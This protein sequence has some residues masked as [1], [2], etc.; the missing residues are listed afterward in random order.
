MLHM[1]QCTSSTPQVKSI[2]LNPILVFPEYPQCSDLVV[3]P[4]KDVIDSLLVHFSPKKIDQRL[5]H[6]NTMLEVT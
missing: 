4:I 1:V 3:Q 5:D 6:T 2:I